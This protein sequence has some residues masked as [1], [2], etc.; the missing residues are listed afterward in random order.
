M[1]L[2]LPITLVLGIVVL[3]LIRKSGLK[4]WHS[5]IVILFGFYLS[6]TT[7]AVHIRQLDA[8]VAG[9]LGGTLHWR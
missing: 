6:A 4:I 8:T 9:L 1:Q 3:F 2:S 7:A 5:L